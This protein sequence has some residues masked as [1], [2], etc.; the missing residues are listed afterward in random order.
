MDIIFGIILVYW[1]IK[2]LKFFLGLF[3]LFAVVYLVI[4]LIWIIL[5]YLLA[6]IAVLFLSALIGNL[7]GAIKNCSK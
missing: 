6:F 3:A 5:P 4:C 1:I 7:T 2:A